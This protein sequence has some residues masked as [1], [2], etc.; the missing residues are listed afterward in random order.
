MKVG[1]PSEDG[2]EFGFVKGHAF[3]HAVK[4]AKILGALAL[5]Y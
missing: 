2:F 5:R 4:D 3:R 1:T